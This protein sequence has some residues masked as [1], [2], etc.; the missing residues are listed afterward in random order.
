MNGRDDTLF[1]VFDMRKWRQWSLMIGLALFT[2]IF[3]WAET[4]GTISVFSKDEPTAVTKG[5]SDEPNIALTFNISWGEERVHEI[6]EKLEENDVQATFFLSGEWAERHPK[7]VEKITEQSHE[8]GM[9]GYRY[10]SYLDQK[11]EQVRKDILHAK[12]VFTKLGHEDMKYM[13][14]PSGHFNKEIIDLAES[15]DLEVI[16]WNINT[17]DWTNP[18]TEEIVNTVMKETDNGDIVLFH[19]SD[20]VKQTDKALETI[21]P[22]LAEKGFTF[23]PISELISEADSEI[24]LVE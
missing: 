22:A 21:L 11:V 3:I 10:K 4:S 20:S 12:E 17:N 5:N 7:I 19:A 14:T 18:G 8:I 9:L 6:L 1:Y 13:R 24:T 16:H 2:A 23:V 15:L